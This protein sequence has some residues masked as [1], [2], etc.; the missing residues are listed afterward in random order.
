MRPPASESQVLLV[1][2]LG[3]FLS[4]LSS[5]IVSVILPEI[6]AWASIG[7]HSVAWVTL[8]PMLV[9]SVL[10]LPAGW[11]G[12][13]FGHRNTY[14]A[15]AAFA[16]IGSLGCALAPNFLILLVFRGFQGV[17]AAFAMASAPALITLTARPNHRGGA[18]G[19]S[20]TA[21]YAGLTLGPPLGGWLSS[22]AGFRAVFVAQVPLSALLLIVSRTMLP[23]IRFNP[24]RGSRRL[25]WPGALLL[26]LGISGV[27]LGLGRRGDDALL[28]GLGGVATLLLFL[29]IEKRASGPLLDLSLFSSR[30]FVSAT[31]GAFLNYAA[32]F[33][34]NFLLPFYLI[35]ARQMDAGHAGTLLMTTPLVMTFVA[36]PSGHLSDR[37]GS[38][39]LAALGMLILAMG[40]LILSNAGLN[41]DLWI[42]AATLVL[43]GAG[44][45]IF[46][47]PNTSTLMVSAPRTAQGSA[48]GVMALARTLGMMVGIALAALV[49]EFVRTSR[50]TEGI[51]EAD[52]LGYQ[53]AWVVGAGIAIAGFFVSLIRS[54]K[55]E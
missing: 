7:V 52:V 9:I 4:S 54:G 53:T 19:V 26:G 46:V 3:S 5:S 45:G 42:I 41:T 30:S 48:A 1:A 10:L 11:A 21:L 12:D 31:L 13:S 22:L 33:H 18:L 25:D 32:L 55:A 15:G 29:L 49:H 14:I 34:A 28:F 40:L 2:A 6:G 27:F 43:V 8:A 37:F 36:G 23:D 38:R 50:A 17:G 51:A 47:A 24:T 20:S 16:T 35:E 44:T 39:P